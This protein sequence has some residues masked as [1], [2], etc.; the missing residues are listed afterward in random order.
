MDFGVA[1]T[2]FFY[3]V[4]FPCLM[5]LPVAYTFYLL[6]DI[7]KNNRL[8]PKGKRRQLVIYFFRLVLVFVIMWVPALVFL[9][10]TGQWLNPWVK[11]VGGTWCHIQGAASA[12]ACLW[13]PDVSRAVLELLQCRVW[14]YYRCCR[15]YYIGDKAAAD[16]RDFSSGLGFRRSGMRRNSSFS[17]FSW[18]NLSFLGRGRE[19]NPT[20]MTMNSSDG[21]SIGGSRN[22]VFAPF[23]SNAISNNSSGR[24]SLGNSSNSGFAPFRSKVLSN[25]SST[26]DHC[27]GRESV[28]ADFGSNT[29]LT[30]LDL[31]QDVEEHEE[32][33]GLKE[34]QYADDAS[35]HLEDEYNLAGLQE[36]R[37]LDRSMIL[38]EE[39]RPSRRTALVPQM[40]DT[41][42][43]DSQD[44]EESVGLSLDED[45]DMEQPTLSL[46]E[47]TLSIQGQEDQQ[48]RADAVCSLQ[49]KNK[50]ALHKESGDRNDRSAIL[51][52]QQRPSRRAALVPETIDT[53]SRCSKGSEEA[54]EAC[55]VE[56]SKDEEQEQSNLNPEAMSVSHASRDQQELALAADEIIDEDEVALSQ[57]LQELMNKH[58]AALSQELQDIEDITT[59]STG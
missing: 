45:E 19:Q 6:F 37:D 28:P 51:L 56:L 18:G 24:H 29:S 27:R 39:Q 2:F 31:G 42:S 58:E 41:S 43:N 38:L 25:D 13:K 11:W 44:A 47:F 10:I 16:I 8:P 52:S 15:K 9:F 5:G 26:K 49:D 30:L 53:A 59:L 4:F 1:S 54:D 50:V 17:N 36:P 14:R 20:T 34:D 35:A 57:E 7:L 12:I 40:I 22:S 48:Q 3:C 33:G 55:T 21:L 46:G 32:L 23:G